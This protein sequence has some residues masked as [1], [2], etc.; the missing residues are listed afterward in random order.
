MSVTVPRH[1]VNE[2]T[3]GD[4]TCPGSQK[5][6]CSLSFEGLTS[7]SSEERFPD[8]SEIRLIKSLYGP[9]KTG[10]DH[11]V[12]GGIACFLYCLGSFGCDF[13]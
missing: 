6:L 11:R 8:A 2:L 9:D 1:G 4:V 10:P 12:L 3:R 7:S 5:G 13:L